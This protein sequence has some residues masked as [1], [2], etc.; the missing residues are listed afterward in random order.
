M[1]FNRGIDNPNEYEN[2]TS[3]CEHSYELLDNMHEA[4]QC[5]S[6]HVH[7]H[8]NIHVIQD[9]DC[10]GLTSAAAIC[11]YTKR[12][13]PECRLTYSI[14]SGKQ[15]GISREINVPD[16]TQ[17]LIIPDASSNDVDQCKMLSDKGVDI[18]ILDHHECEDK[19]PHAIVVNNQM[20]DYPNKQLSG[21]GVVYKFLQ[22]VDDEEWNGGA[23]EYLDLVAVG[24][25]G[26]NMDIKSYETKYIV[27]KGLKRIKNRLLKALV[28]KTNYSTNGEVTIRNVQFYI[29][30]LINGMIRAGDSEEKEILFRAAIEDYDEFEYKNRKT[31]TVTMEDIFTRAARFCVNA[32]IR[33]D[34][35]NYKSLDSIYNFIDKHHLDE[36][37]IMMVNVTNLL[38]KSQTGV[39]AIKVANKYHKPTLLLR[40]N[41]KKGVFAG[42]GRNCNNSPIQNLKDFLNDLGVFNYCEGHQGAF[43]IEVDI[44]NIQAAIDII[45]ST[46]ADVSMEPV[47]YV[48]FVIYEEY[49]S[50]ALI[51]QIDELKEYFGTGFPEVMVCVKNVLVSQENY[52]VIGKNKDTWKVEN[53]DGVVLINFKFDE[54]DEVNTILSSGGDCVIDVVGKAMLNKFGG[55]VTPQIVISDYQV[56]EDV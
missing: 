43:G 46:L 28:E 51:K 38:D 20:C 13:Y 1:F 48:D 34:K 23:D 52:Y 36:N 10:D 29:V 44:E 18:I 6:K 56:I 39:S 50:I 26:D 4:V 35:S 33:Q 5:Y 14:H 12:F 21:V 16:D 41:E 47:A 49:L 3:N 19:N 53:D 37:K 42:S 40:K 2:L 22:A 9:P 7:K 11:L 32:K 55:I 24:L 45:N 27:D 30:P 54:K 15:H 25:I 31:Q 8:H 17:L